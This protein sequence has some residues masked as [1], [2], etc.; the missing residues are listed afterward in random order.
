MLAARERAHS[1]LELTNPAGLAVMAL[2]PPDGTASFTKPG[3]K[4]GERE[5]RMLRIP[6]AFPRA[7]L[8]AFFP[9]SLGATGSAWPEDELTAALVG[10]WRNTT[11][12]F[13][14]PRDEQL[15]LADDGTTAN[16]VVTDEFERSRFPAPG[17]ATTL[18]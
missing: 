17:R 12:R 7:V 3:C 15:V 14:Q 5:A 2:T 6:R 10:H 8:P 18:S 13:E 1:A 16:C 11:I 4:P 9:S